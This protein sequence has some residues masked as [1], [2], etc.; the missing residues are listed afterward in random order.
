MSTGERQKGQR[1]QKSHKGITGTRN[2]T[3]VTRTSWAIETYERTLS[4]D[5]HLPL[6]ALSI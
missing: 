1:G 3:S 6:P 5:S 2:S 4:V